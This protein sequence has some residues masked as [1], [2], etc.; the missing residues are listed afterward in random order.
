MFSEAL[1]ADGKWENIDWPSTAGKTLST[2]PSLSIGAQGLTAANSGLLWAADVLF[3]SP[4]NGYKSSKEEKERRNEK[5]TK[6][7]IR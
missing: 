6:L 7:D 5:R 2:F 4:S 1:K 3:F